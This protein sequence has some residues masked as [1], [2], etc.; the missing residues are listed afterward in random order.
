MATSSGDKA[1][2]LKTSQHSRMFQMFNHVVKGSE[3]EHGKPAPDIF[4]ECARRFPDGAKINPELCLGFEDSPNGVLAVK[5]AGMQAVMIPD[6]RMPK[7]LTRKADYVLK[8]GHDFRPERFGLPAYGYRPVTHVIFD[9]DGLLLNTTK[10]YSEVTR[11]ILERHGKTPCP[12]FG[13]SVRGMR[14]VDF[15][16]EAI[17]FYGLPY[18]VEEYD[19]EYKKLIV[20]LFRDTTEFLEGVETFLAH[21]HKHNIPM[22][23]ATSSNATGVEHKM[24]RHRAVFDR[25]SHVVT[26]SDPELK[27]GKPAPDIFQMAADRFGD[28]PD[29]ANCLVFED[30][31]NGVVA[32]GAAGMQSVMILEGVNKMDPKKT[33]QATQLLSSMTEFRP[34]DFGLPAYD[35]Q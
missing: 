19:Q 34:Q 7:D 9:M 26:G 3:V 8:S 4:L 33:V 16:Q 21:L 1:F 23:V 5:A 10:A 28:K 13:L 2:E 30:A 20:P 31:P 29:H 14:F 15:A 6:K 17:D 18:T 35:E 24:S 11:I 25:F 32:A 27:N 22:A 12:E